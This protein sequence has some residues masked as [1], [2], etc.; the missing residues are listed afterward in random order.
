MREIF[1]AVLFTIHFGG[2]MNTSLGGRPVTAST[3]VRI[4]VCSA[5]IASGVISSS[6][7][8]DHDQLLGAERFVRD[9]NATTRPAWMP[10]TSLT[11]A[12]MSSG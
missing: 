5:G 11:A 7:L 1:P 12:S 10:A 6:G 8:G 9:P 4:S 2:T 3:E